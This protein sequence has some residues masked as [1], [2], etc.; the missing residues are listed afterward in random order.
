MPSS[1]TRE[2]SPSR[3]PASGRAESAFCRSSPTDSRSFK[4]STTA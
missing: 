1:E 3:P 4:R 2:R